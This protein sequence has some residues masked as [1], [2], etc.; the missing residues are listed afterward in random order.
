MYCQQC[1]REIRQSARFCN[2][3]GAEVKERFPESKPPA[4][5]ESSPDTGSLTPPVSFK[6]P[7]PQ[8]SWLPVEE[9]LI[10]P[11]VGKPGLDDPR[12]GKTEAERPASG[13]TQ[14]E[15][16]TIFESSAPKPAPPPKPKG[17]GAPSRPQAPPQGKKSSPRDFARKP[18]FTEFMPAASNRQHDRLLIVI[19]ILV[20]IFIGVIVLAYIANKYK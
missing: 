8:Q 13:G 1:G 20:L 9:T 16:R 11:I 2:K 12:A 6:K 3:C 7:A 17:D 5:S 18:V 10:M 19:P 14:A 4:R 15:R